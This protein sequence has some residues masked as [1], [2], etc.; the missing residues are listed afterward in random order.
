MPILL[1]ALI[2]LTFSPCNPICTEGG[3]TV[4]SFPSTVA[5]TIGSGGIVMSL[6][7]ATGVDIRLGTLFI[8]SGKMENVVI[9]GFVT[10]CCCI[11]VYIGM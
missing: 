7:T 2:S 9:R 1:F 8:I 4:I 3:S 10:V 11:V 5:T 6:F